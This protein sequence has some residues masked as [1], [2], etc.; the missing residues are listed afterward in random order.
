M[1]SPHYYNGAMGLGSNFRQALRFVL[2]GVVSGLVLF[3]FSQT[4]T[5]AKTTGV[6]D[7]VFN[8]CSL[9]PT[10]LCISTGFITEAV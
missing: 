7:V 5:P 2:A 9:E 10:F 8:R 1:K 3:G 6:L 4:E